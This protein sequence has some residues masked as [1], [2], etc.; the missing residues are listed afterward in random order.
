MESHQGPFGHVRF[1]AKQKDEYKLYLCTQE[2]CNRAYKTEKGFFKHISQVHGIKKYSKEAALPE[3]EIVAG[4]QQNQCVALK[5]CIDLDVIKKATIDYQ[6][7]KNN[8]Q[9][10][11]HTKMLEEMQKHYQ[12]PDCLAARI[13]TE[14]LS[15]EEKLLLLDLLGSVSDVCTFPFKMAEISNQ[16]VPHL[17]SLAKY[18]TVSTGGDLIRYNATGGDILR[19]SATGGELFNYIAKDKAYLQSIMAK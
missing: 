3:P 5:N 8:C 7:S 2:F 14:F 16:D 17:P 9:Q 19:Y 15:E 6:K 1:A 12:R 18:G 11:A 4:A 10:G 13:P